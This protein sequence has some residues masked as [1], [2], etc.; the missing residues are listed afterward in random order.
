MRNVGGGR[1]R[2]RTT[3]C[4]EEI[5]EVENIPENKYELW[6]E[7]REEVTRFPWEGSS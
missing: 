7:Q 6:L 3:W 2:E 1:E 5:M 4:R